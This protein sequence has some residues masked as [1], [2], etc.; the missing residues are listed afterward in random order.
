MERS[1]QFGDSNIIN[2]QV[3]DPETRTSHSQ[4]FLEAVTKVYNELFDRALAREKRLLI[5]C[6]RAKA[7]DLEVAEILA[8][9]EIRQYTQQEIDTI[10]ANGGWDGKKRKDRTLC[11]R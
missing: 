3:S 9:H 10:N 2:R 6:S 4:G 1:W 11:A 8:G 7:G 5:L